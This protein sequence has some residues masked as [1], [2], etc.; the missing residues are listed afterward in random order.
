MFIA[1]DITD[2]TKK[3]IVN[4]RHCAQNESSIRFKENIQ[5]KLFQSQNVQ[6]KLESKKPWKNLHQCEKIYFLFNTPPRGLR[7]EKLILSCVQTKLFEFAGASLHFSF[8]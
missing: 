3:S 5:K 1:F 4:A 7:T 6:Q 2:D 8:N